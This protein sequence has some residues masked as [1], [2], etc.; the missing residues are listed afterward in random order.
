[1][2]SVRLA[3]GPCDRDLT[4]EDVCIN[5]DRWSVDD[6]EGIGY[7]V[8]RPLLQCV[9]SFAAVVAKLW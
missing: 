6:M 9:A 4:V 2:V 3:E 1:M 8:L 5:L 7:L